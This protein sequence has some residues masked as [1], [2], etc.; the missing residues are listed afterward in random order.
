M[1]SHFRRHAG[2][3]SALHR[4]TEEIALNI[5]KRSW[6]NNVKKVIESRLKPF[7]YHS[8]KAKI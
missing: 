1:D 4:V 8:L 5:L 3:K 6:P 2:G 7:T